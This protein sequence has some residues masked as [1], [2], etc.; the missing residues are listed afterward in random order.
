MSLLISLSAQQPDVKNSPQTPTAVIVIRPHHF[1]ANPETAEDN[2]FQNMAANAEQEDAV[3]AYHEVSNT[4]DILRSHGVNVHVFEDEERHTPDSVFPNN[5]FST[6]AGGHIAIYPMYA[7]NRRRE[8]RT[9]I[10]EMLK[11]SYRVQD[12]VDYSGME[13]DGLFLEGTGAM[14]LDHIERVAY[15]CKSRRADPILLE[16]FCSQ[17]NYEPIVFEAFDN[18]GRA[19]Y[20]TNVLMCIASDIVLV[21]AEMVRD[22]DQ[23]TALLERLKNT[24]REILELSEAQIAAFA[25]NMLEVQGAN[26]ALLVMSETARRALTYEQIDQIEQRLPIVNLP[27]P[28]IEKA[29]GSVRCMLAGVHLSKR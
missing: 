19:V 3:R 5:W 22:N 2:A 4:V 17:F 20:H 27:I 18:E 10:I 7:A 13:N 25:G 1:T 11:H 28:T 29:G 26:G 21:G 16:R 12:V 6:H 8:R 14:V 9:D 15:V 24:G 23:R